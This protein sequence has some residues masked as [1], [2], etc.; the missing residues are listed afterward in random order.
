MEPLN[1]LLGIIEELDQ[2]VPEGHED[3]RT[4]LESHRSST[5]YSAPELLT[6][7]VV[8][9]SDCLREYFETRHPFDKGSWED[10]SAEVWAKG[11]DKLLEVVKD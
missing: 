5:A 9:L 6:L 8:E 10:Q 2:L 4:I 3:L 7:R 1:C 11:M